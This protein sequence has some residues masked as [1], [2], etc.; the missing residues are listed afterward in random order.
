MPVKS[1]V[2]LTYVCLD[3]QGSFFALT[4]YGLDET[5]MPLAHPKSKTLQIRC[6]CLNQVNVAWQT[7]TYAFPSIRV[8]QTEALLDGNGKPLVSD[9]SARP[10]DIRVTTTSQ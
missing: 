5:K 4:I 1:Q 2:A 10:T 7:K 6:P 8:N 3:S 9:T